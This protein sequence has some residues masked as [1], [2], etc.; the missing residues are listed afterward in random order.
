MH[1]AMGGVHEQ[2]RD[3]RKYSVK[4]NWENVQAEY[5]NQYA[6]SQ[7]TVNNEPYDYRSIL[8]YHLSV[9]HV[10][11]NIESDIHFYLVV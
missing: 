10:T 6:L 3:R 8:Q 5:N 11:V 9:S 4:I 2:Q 1:H 7:H